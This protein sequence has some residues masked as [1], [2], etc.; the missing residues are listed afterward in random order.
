MNLVQH[1]FETLHL[2]R[3]L[4]HIPKIKFHFSVAKLSNKLSKVDFLFPLR[5]RLDEIT[6]EDSA[7]AH[8]IC[9]MIPSQC[10][11]EREVKVLGHTLIKIPPMCK[12]NP[13]YNELVFL[14]FRA[15]CYLSDTCGEDISIYC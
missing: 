6:I 2:D 9:K 13:L 8:R 14:R 7:F 11:F 15:M 5:Q 4:S 10:P 12:L 3:W 1:T